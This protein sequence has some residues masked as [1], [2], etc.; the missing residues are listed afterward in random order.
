MNANTIY[1]SGQIREQ[2]DFKYHPDNNFLHCSNKGAHKKTMKVLE[3]ILSLWI[4]DVIQNILI[5][6]TETL[7]QYL[8]ISVNSGSV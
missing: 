2:V 7:S 4:H 6:R 5:T 1:S 8:L 3:L